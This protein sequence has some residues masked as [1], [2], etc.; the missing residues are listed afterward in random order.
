MRGHQLYA[1][2]LRKNPRC[3]ATSTFF[4]SLP[5]PLTH[6]L[7]LSTEA[8]QLSLSSASGKAARIV[9]AAF[10][11]SG[12]SKQAKSTT[13][14][15]PPF[16]PLS[17]MGIDVTS[18]LNFAHL[19]QLTHLLDLFSK[20]QG[21]PARANLKHVHLEKG[22][23]SVVAQYI[24]IKL[25]GCFPRGAPAPLHQHHFFMLPYEYIKV[26]TVSSLSLLFNMYPVL[27]ELFSQS[28]FASHLNC[29]LIAFSCHFVQ[30]VFNALAKG[31]Y[32]HKD[33]WADFAPI[34]PLP[35]HGRLS[36]VL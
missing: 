14:P 33:N 15:S 17:D 30:F 21:N 22:Q 28:F 2:S 11:F 20:P 26:N 36:S 7:L 10:K 27:H 16:I 5:V 1:E 32:T 18:P 34:L 31:G 29:F 3:Q 19:S 23:K 24:F 13:F 25:H 6:W 9:P 12:G 35:D 4:S 8:F